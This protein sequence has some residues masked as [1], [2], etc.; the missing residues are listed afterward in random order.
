MVEL[1]DSRRLADTVVSSKEE[2]KK[3]MESW[4]QKY[5]DD[6]D[7]ILYNKVTSGENLPLYA[8]EVDDLTFIPKTTTHKRIRSPSKSTSR[9][10]RSSSSDNFDSVLA[11]FRNEQRQIFEN[12]DLVSENFEQ[13][14]TSRSNSVIY[15]ASA[16]LRRGRSSRTVRFEPEDSQTDDI[17]RAMSR[18]TLSVRKYSK[19]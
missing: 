3:W 14:G 2:Y 10:S 9:A 12:F 8:Y 1:A 4:I 7:Y 17:E 19:K 18:S 15:S 5:P 16:S 6:S 11:E 13:P